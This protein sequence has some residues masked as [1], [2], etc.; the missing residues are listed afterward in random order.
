M[1]EC[2]GCLYNLHLQIYVHNNNNNNII[3]K[4]YS[5]K[6]PFLK[7]TNCNYV[8]YFNIIY[9]TLLSNYYFHYHYGLSRC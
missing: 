8:A 5:Q 7:A 1:R 9:N 6:F 2:I 4:Y 3:Y